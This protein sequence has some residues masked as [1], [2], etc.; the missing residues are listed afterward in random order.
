MINK[1]I[2]DI[3][4]ALVAE[5]YL[6]ALAL[7]LTLPDICA[8][9]EYGD[10]IKINKERYIKWYDE[11]IGQYEKPTEDFGAN[12]TPYLSGEVVYQ[13]RCNYLH[14]GTATVDK[15]KIKEERCKLDKLILCVAKTNDLDIYTDCS[16]VEY[17]PLHK[18]YDVNVQRLC[19]L[20]KQA[21]LHCFKNN[22]EKFNSF[23][24]E[25]IDLDE[26]TYGKYLS[27]EVETDV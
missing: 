24:Y 26:L 9:A 22:K 21:S 12:S 20:L 2:E 8:K 3:D 23:N 19:F 4:K 27:N 17:N 16:S 10:E 18:E 15:E 25:I 11:Y 13:L 5:A 6:S 7:A 1:I 14:Q